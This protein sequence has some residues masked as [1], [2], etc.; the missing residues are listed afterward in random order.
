MDDFKQA[1]QLYNA[2]QYAEAKN[3]LERVL[4]RLTDSPDRAKALSFFG[5]ASAAVGEVEAGLAAVEE[6]LRLAPDLP[7]AHTLLAH[8][9]LHA[10]NPAEAVGPLKHVASVN[11]DDIGVAQSLAH[12]L[13]SLGRHAE[14]LPAFERLGMLA[15]DAPGVTVTRA[16]LHWQLGQLDQSSTLL[17]AWLQTYTDDVEALTYLGLVRKTQGRLAEAI[18]HFRNALELDHGHREATLNLAMTLQDSGE[19]TA[20]AELLDTYLQAHPSPAVGMLNALVLP[21]ILESNAGID[22]WRRRLSERLTQ[23]VEQ[24]QTLA[25]PL[26]DVGMLQFH[27]AYQCRDDVALQKQLADTYLKLCPSLGYVSPSLAKPGAR[28]RIKIGFLSANLRSHTVGWLNVGYI[29]HL[30]RI[31]FEVH[32]IAPEGLSGADG[33][34]ERIEDAADD[35]ITVPRDLAKARDIIATQQYDVLYYPDIGMDAFTYYLAFARLAPV[36]AVAWGHPVTTGIPNMDYFVSCEDMEP[37]SGESA[38][39]ETL[40]RLPDMGAYLLQLERP[41]SALNRAPYSLPEGQPLLVC[42]QSCFKFHPDFDRLLKRVLEAV[43]EA[44]LVLLRGSPQTP[45]DMLSQRLK[46]NLGN[47]ADRVRFVGPLQQDDYFLLAAESTVVLDIPQWSGGRSSY[48]CLA[49]G[50]PIVHLPGPFMR[51]RHTL[52]F[53]RAMET[54]ICLAESED[55]YVKIVSRLVQD[56]QFNARVRD[57]IAEKSDRLFERKTAVVALEEFFLNSLQA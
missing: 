18:T 28:E 4:P 53:Y 44:I 57:E 49:M 34:R 13:L 33:L 50:A 21:I 54:D 22:A 43:P 16:A 7:V 11:P 35:V 52:A 42:P 23:L 38:Y 40:I 31:K 10:G 56:P 45:S 55:D 20:A 19:A 29:E 14:A 12:A 51:G 17:E 6:A 32:V 2:G 30:D 47:A 1:V 46:K 48:E 9:H 8:V 39:S 37:D 26:H 36:Q 24:G 5:G 27:L 3:T 41:N 25:D 15:P